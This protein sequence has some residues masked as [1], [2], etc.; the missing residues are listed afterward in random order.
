V[1]RQRTK[2]AVLL[3]PTAVGKSALALRLA[4]DLGL[5]IISC[6]SR[7]IYR[8][9]DIGTAKPTRD[10]MARV[11]HW[12]VDIADPSQWY[13][14]YEFAHDAARIIETLA[15]DGRRALI[16]GGTGFYFRGLSEGL[17]MRLASDW[18]LRE[19]YEK[20]VREEGARTILEELRDVDA[21]TAQR[22]HPNDTRRII[23]ALEVYHTTGVPQSELKKHSCPPGDF[24]FCVTVVTLPRPVLYGR[25]EARVE[26]MVAEGLWKEFRGLREAGYDERSPGLQ[27]VGYRELFEVERGTMTLQE[28]CVR[29]K[30]NT[31][32]YAK[33]QMT[34]FRH[35]TNA[36]FED[37]SSDRYDVIRRRVGAHL[38]VR[39]GG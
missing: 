27:C 21:E 2:V 19:A 20:R 6:D 31:R 32:R 18:S 15:S 14:A 26:R 36:V 25:I 12:L 38:V 39:A 22:L 7:Q 23:R 17:G 13:S 10:E 1:A 16:C 4:D 33:R 28:A 9:M 3:G 35:Q 11:K 30:Q 37:L 5:D 34:W 24:E 8:G 29:M